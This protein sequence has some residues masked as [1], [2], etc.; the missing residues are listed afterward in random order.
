M[1]AERGVTNFYWFFILYL[2]LNGLCEL[3]NLG[4]NPTNVVQSPGRCIWKFAV[5]KKDY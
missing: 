4:I 1:L 3:S 2:Q 5:D